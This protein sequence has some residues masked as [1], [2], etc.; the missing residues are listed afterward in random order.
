MYYVW[1]DGI[2]MN[3]NFQ[4]WQIQTGFGGEGQTASLGTN[5]F[6]YFVGL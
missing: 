1:I 5:Y 6:V 4:Q 2:Y 3:L